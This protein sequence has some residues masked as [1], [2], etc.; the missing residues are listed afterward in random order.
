MSSYEKE[1]KD[2]ENNPE[3]WRIIDENKDE[4]AAVEF[5]EKYRKANL[6][7]PR[8]KWILFTREEKSRVYR[9][10][11][12]LQSKFGRLSGKVKKI[13]MEKHGGRNLFSD[14]D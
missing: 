11:E 10:R 2:R 6:R 9:R 13:V 1:K 7:V 4:E 12:E 8:S 5:L 14:L 3:K